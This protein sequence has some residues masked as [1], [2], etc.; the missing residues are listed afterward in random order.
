MEQASVHGHDGHGGPLSSKA[1]CA[2]VLVPLHSPNHELPL[3]DKRE[4]GYKRVRVDPK[5]IGKIPYLKKQHQGHQHDEFF[6]RHLRAAKI[7]VWVYVPERARA[8]TS[9][10]PI[11]QS[12]VDTILRGCLA[13]GGEDLCAEFLKKTTG[14]HPNTH[15]QDDDE[16]NNNNNSDTSSDTSDKTHTASKI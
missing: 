4:Q 3:F 9:C 15:I 13:T 1:S 14:W 7:Q 8:P 16:S 2:G 6:Q 11:A 5:K 10:H 12:Y